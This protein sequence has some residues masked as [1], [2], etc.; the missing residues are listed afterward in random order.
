MVD[1]FAA[2]LKLYRSTLFDDVLPFWDRHA[3]AASGGISTC[4][5][6]DG[7]IISGDHW[8]WSQ[9]RAVW[10]WSRLYNAFGRRREFLDR[11]RGIYQFVTANGPLQNGHWP[12]LL[13]RDGTILRG[14]ESLYVDGFALYGL[15]E[16]FRATG[17]EGVRRHAERTYAAVRA[18]LAADLPPPAFPYPIPP[19]QMAHGISMIFSLAFHELAE[20]TGASAI[21]EAA[22]VQHRMVMDVFNRADRRVVLERL[23]RDGGELPP[24]E[25]TAVVPGH[26]IESMAFQ[27]LIARARGDRETCRRA[28]EVIHRHLELGW[29][30]EYG[31]LIL[32]VDADGREPVGWQHATTKL[33][34]P[35]VEALWATLLAYEATREPWCLAWHARVREYSYAHFPDHEH[36]EWRQKLDRQGRPLEET[37][38]LPVKDPFH[39][40]RALMYCIEVLE[41]LTAE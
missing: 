21:A 13:D 19:G 8:N 10:V 35:H 9:W 34:W 26:A 29:D 12:L 16:L 18:A 23:S 28:A 33:W 3:F 39:L 27:M 20:A 4:I 37:L 25:G 1:D 36:G 6:D 17:D 41:R 14:Y 40:P 7:K 15:T 5:A 32:A 31:G 2:L 22:T 24:P 38:V 11:A 30:H